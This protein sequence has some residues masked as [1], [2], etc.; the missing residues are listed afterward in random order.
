MSKSASKQQRVSGGRIAVM[1]ISVLLLSFIMAFGM[2][3]G[4]SSLKHNG[5]VVLG[6]DAKIGRAHV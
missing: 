4:I 5:P 2:L 6:E 3:L 1:I